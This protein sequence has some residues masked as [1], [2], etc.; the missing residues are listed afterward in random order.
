MMIVSRPAR[1][2]R[3]ELTGCSVIRSL[4][5]M[6]ESVRNRLKRPDNGPSRWRQSRSVR[7]NSGVCQLHGGQGT[8]LG[9]RV[10]SSEL[11]LQLSS[12]LAGESSS[13][14]L[15]QNGTRSDGLTLP[16]G[17][18]DTTPP[19]DRQHPP[20]RVIVVELGKPVVF[21]VDGPLGSASCKA[22]EGT[23]G[24][25]SRRKRMP[26]CNGPDRRQRAPPERALTS[27]WCGR[28]RTYAESSR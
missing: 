17:H 23:A 12:L 1:R 21:P 6:A 2:E 3:V 15:S 22:R 27:A 18:T 26:G 19:V 24:K 4:W 10:N 20:H 16:L 28:A 9:G 11:L 8:R 5:A 13:M 14:R 7:I 25:G